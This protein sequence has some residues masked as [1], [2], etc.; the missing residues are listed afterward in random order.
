MITQI[1]TEK[2]QGFDIVTNA[3][4]EHDIPDWDMTPSE[5]RELYKDLDRGNLVWFRVQVIAFKNNIPLGEDHLGG[6]C[7]ETYEDFILD[8]YYR[9]MRQT[10][11]QRARDEIKQLCTFYE[12]V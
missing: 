4:V 1:H 7:Y 6:C 3:L 5:R 2:Y 9:D 12:S 8:E 10:C 11:V